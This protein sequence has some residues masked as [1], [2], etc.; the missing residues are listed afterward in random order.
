MQANRG[1]YIY[2]NL[3][4]STSF[5][6]QYESSQDQ[7]IENDHNQTSLLM[8]CEGKSRR[9]HENGANLE[10]EDEYNQTSLLSLTLDELR[11]AIAITRSQVSIT[12][13]LGVARI[14]NT[15]MATCWLSAFVVKLPCLV[16][17]KV[18][19]YDLLTRDRPAKV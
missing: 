9:S 5:R 6:R 13:T 17:M 10:A 15:T 19:T 18:V 3:T 7:P 11:S 16:S 12:W 8:G 2:T 14:S 1:L 4:I